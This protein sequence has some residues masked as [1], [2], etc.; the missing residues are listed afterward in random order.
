M[1]ESR[2][3]KWQVKQKE[4]GNCVTCGKKA[5]TKHYCREHQDKANILRLR[6]YYENKE[7]TT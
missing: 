5:V 1:K 2:Q 4:L 7:Q 6:Y 3:K